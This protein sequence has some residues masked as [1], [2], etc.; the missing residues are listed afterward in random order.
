VKIKLNQLRQTKRLS[1]FFHNFVNLSDIK[2]VFH[3]TQGLSPHI[4][5]VT[6]DKI[7]YCGETWTLKDDECVL[8]GYFELPGARIDSNTQEFRQHRGINIF[9][10]NKIDSVLHISNRVS[11]TLNFESVLFKN[12]DV[13]FL[14]VYRNPRLAVGNFKKKFEAVLS[15][16]FKCKNYELIRQRIRRQE[17]VSGEANKQIN[18]LKVNSWPTV[19][20]MFCGGL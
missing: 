3:N 6:N 14:V 19:I 17:K 10:K 18:N 15:S 16:I 4:P 7:L 12:K 13:L 1:V 20:C 9:I 2:I 11:C 5:D 8:P